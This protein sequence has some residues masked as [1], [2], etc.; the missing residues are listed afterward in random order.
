MRRNVNVAV[1]SPSEDG[2]PNVRGLAVGVASCHD[3]GPSG[4]RTLMVAGKGPPGSQHV[5]RDVVEEIQQHL[6]ENEAAAFVPTLSEQLRLNTVDPKYRHWRLGTE[7]CN[8]PH[9]V[10]EHCRGMVQKQH[11]IDEMLRSLRWLARR[12]EAGVSKKTSENPKCQK[13]VRRVERGGWLDAAGEI[14]GEG[15]KEQHQHRVHHAPGPEEPGACAW[16]S[17]QCPPSDVPLEGVM[18]GAIPQQR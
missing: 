17:Q 7:D 18:N 8:S 1:V 3:G 14:S 5:E 16:P 15:A 12:R 4:E 6:R 9:D 2:G 13:K 11:V 10:Q